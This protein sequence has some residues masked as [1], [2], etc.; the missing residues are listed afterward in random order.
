MLNTVIAMFQQHLLDAERR[1]TL[2]EDKLELQTERMFSMLHRQRSGSSTSSATST[3]SMT[4]QLQAM[5]PPSQ[6]M[7]SIM[8]N[9]S[10]ASGTMLQPPAALQPQMSSLPAPMQMFSSQQIPSMQLQ[11]QM[12]FL[13][14]TVPILQSTASVPA[15]MQT[16]VPSASL[17]PRLAPAMTSGPPLAPPTWLPPSEDGAPP[18]RFQPPSGQISQDPRFQACISLIPQPDSFASVVT[19]PPKP[20]KPRAITPFLGAQDTRSVHSWLSQLGRALLIQRVPASM[21]VPETIEL[22][23]D[24]V[25]QRMCPGIRNLSMIGFRCPGSGLTSVSG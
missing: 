2:L 24:S 18:L 3:P 21:W 20:F 4:P 22:L 7:P 8:P 13:P 11:Q 10:Q 17:A 6:L 5:P 19:A 14:P 23:H 12:P 9:S 15:Q 25:V 1:Q 16:I